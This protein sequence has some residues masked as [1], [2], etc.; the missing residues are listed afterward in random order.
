M[1]LT[2][3]CRDDSCFSV[4]SLLTSLSRVGGCIDTPIILSN[5]KCRSEADALFLLRALGMK[6]MISARASWTG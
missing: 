3:E 4:R 2:L 6:L 1:T 5:C